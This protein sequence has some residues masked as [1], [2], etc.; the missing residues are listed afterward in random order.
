MSIKRSVVVIMKYST[1]A[2]SSVYIRTSLEQQLN[3]FN[4]SLLA[5]HVEREETIL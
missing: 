3:D 5:G 4:I 2:L 1:Y